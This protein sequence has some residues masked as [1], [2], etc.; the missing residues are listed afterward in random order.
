MLTITKME[1]V[2]D[3]LVL[4]QTSPA[5]HTALI[6]WVRYEAS[7]GAGT[8]ESDTPLANSKHELAALKN[9]GLRR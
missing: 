5:L 7:K 2:Q 3:I 4:Y 1:R 6:A 8:A 9:A